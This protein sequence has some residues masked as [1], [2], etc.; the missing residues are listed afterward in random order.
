MEKKITLLDGAM[1]TMLQR[2]GLKLGDRPETLSI[3]SPEVVEGI[4]RQYVQAGAQMILANTFCA[5]AHKLEG[6]GYSVE[7]VVTAS[8]RVALRAAQGSGATVAL[9]VGPIGEMLEPL[10]TLRFEEAYALFAQ[11]FFLGGFLFHILWE[12]KSM[13]VLCYC[14]CLV[15]VAAQSAM[16]LGALLAARREKK[17]APA[18]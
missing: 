3:T 13:Y 15:P 14:V 4:Q 2:A 7:E 18:A 12:T 6:T 9:D 17:A 10:G 11:V 5:N 8:V 16:M 1:G